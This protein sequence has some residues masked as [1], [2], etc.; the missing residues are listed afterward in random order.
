MRTQSHQSQ[1]TLKIITNLTLIY[2]FHMFCNVNTSSV[3]HLHEVHVL[4]NK[5]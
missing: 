3:T 5:P 2:I 4:E 1:K